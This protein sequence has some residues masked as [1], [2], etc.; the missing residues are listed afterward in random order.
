MEEMEW[1]SSVFSKKIRRMAHFG[2]MRTTGHLEVWKQFT[3]FCNLVGI[4]LNGRSYELLFISFVALLRVG[5]MMFVGG[6]FIRHTMLTTL[7][8]H[9]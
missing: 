1:L 5:K 3:S 9:A 7:T 4:G 8:T 2:M 6:F